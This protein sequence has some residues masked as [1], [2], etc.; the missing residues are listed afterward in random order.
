MET[1]DKKREFI[2]SYLETQPNQ[3]NLKVVRQLIEFSKNNNYAAPDILYELMLMDQT[4]EKILTATFDLDF[5]DGVKLF[6][7]KADRWLTD[8][9]QKYLQSLKLQENQSIHSNL[10]PG[11]A[12]DTNTAYDGYL[13]QLIAC[14]DKMQTEADKVTL[15]EF[16]IDLRHL[17]TDSKKLEEGA[18]NKFQPFIERNWRDLSTPMTPILVELSRRFLFAMAY[19]A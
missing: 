9:G 15:Q 7:N 14:K 19:D 5:V 2:L 16:T 18:L 17:L 10:D 11:N 8:R 12:G 4:H 13:T 1:D 3:V 6:N